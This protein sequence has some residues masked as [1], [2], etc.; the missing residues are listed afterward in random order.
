MNSK[1]IHPGRR[2]SIYLLRVTY[3]H[4]LLEVIQLLRTSALDLYPSRQH[5]KQTYFLNKYISSSARSVYLVFREGIQFAC[6]VL[7][8]SSV[9]L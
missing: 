6:L 4:R 8:I 9:L 3:I 7:M 1:F 2:L 5:A